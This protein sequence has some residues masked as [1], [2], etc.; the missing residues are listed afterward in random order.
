MIVPVQG[1]YF[2]DYFTPENIPAACF[3]SGLFSQVLSEC[4]PA[5][6]DCLPAAPALPLCQKPHP[7]TSPVLTS[8]LGQRLRWEMVPQPPERDSSRAAGKRAKTPH[9]LGCLYLRHASAD[10]PQ[11]AFQQVTAGRASYS[12]RIPCSAQQKAEGEA[13]RAHPFLPSVPWHCRTR[14]ADPSTPLSS[15]PLPSPQN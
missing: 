1:G 9:G 11:T 5:C 12:L 3:L 6:T 7:G 10:G 14:K 13:T 15:P 4:C 8:T 2:W